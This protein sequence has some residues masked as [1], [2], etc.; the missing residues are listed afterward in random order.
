MSTT[1]NQHRSL[2]KRGN[3]GDSVADAKPHGKYFLYNLILI[4][5]PKREIRKLER[6]RPQI[7]LVQE[8]SLTSQTST[9]GPSQL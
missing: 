4:Q 8:T 5:H 1:Q 9:L 2:G 3:P 6:P 7:A